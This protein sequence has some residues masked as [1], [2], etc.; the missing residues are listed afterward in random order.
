MEPKKYVSGKHQY[1]KLGPV[2]EVRTMSETKQPSAPQAQLQVDA[3]EA[4]S[5]GVYANLAGIMHTD[6]EFI[7]DFLFLAPNQPKAKLRSRIISSPLHTKRLLSAL[8]D[9][10]RRYEERF[11]PIGAREPK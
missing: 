3:D 9:N 4:T 5:Q 1:T 10:V 8:A 6:T 7:L 2:T 11:G